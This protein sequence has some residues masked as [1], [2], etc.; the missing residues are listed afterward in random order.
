M[1]NLIF[2]T[3]KVAHLLSLEAPSVKQEDLL[4][5]LVEVS[6]TGSA[7]AATFQGEEYYITNT[8]VIMGEGFVENGLI[9]SPKLVGWN[10]GGDHYYFISRDGEYSIAR[11]ERYSTHNVNCFVK[12]A[13]ADVDLVPAGEIEQD[14]AALRPLTAEQ[15]ETFIAQ[16]NADPEIRG[17]VQ[18]EVFTTSGEFPQQLE[19]EAFVSG[20]LIGS[21]IDLDRQAPLRSALQV[22]QAGFPLRDASG[23]YNEAPEVTY[24]AGYPRNKDVESFYAPNPYEYTVKYTGAGARGGYSGGAAMDITDPNDVRFIGISNAVYEVGGIPAFGNIISADSIRDVL[25]ADVHL[26]FEVCDTSREAVVSPS[27]NL[28]KPPTQLRGRLEE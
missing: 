13:G 20:R 24:S 5:G 27:P 4:K 7:V 1:A 14:I 11:L 2:D 16:A 18:L 10:V 21:A 26:A 28:P 22:S 12:G 8:H 19:P 23:E 15:M 17:S 6:E 3:K 9:H 25:R